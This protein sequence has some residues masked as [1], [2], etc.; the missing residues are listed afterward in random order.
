MLP[1]AASRCSP[2][3]GGPRLRGAAAL[4]GGAGRPALLLGVAEAAA[5]AR[6]DGAGWPAVWS[7]ALSLLAVVAAA[8]ARRAGAADRG[9]GPVLGA[10]ALGGGRGRPRRPWSPTPPR[11]PLVR[12]APRRLRARRRLRRGRP[13]RAHRGC[14]CRPGRPVRGVVQVVAGARRRARAGA[15]RAGRRA[16]LGRPAGRRARRRGGRHDAGPA[17][18]GWVAGVLLTASSW[19]RLALADVDAPEAYTVPAGVALLVLGALRRRRDPAYGSWQAYGSGLS[20]GAGAQ[21]AAR[22]H[23]RRRPAAAA[24][25]ARRGRCPRGRRGPPAAG[26]AAPGRGWCSPSTRWCSSR[27]T[28]SRRTTRCRAGSPSAARPR[29]AG[30]RRDVRAA[31]PGPAP[32]RAARRST[33]LTG[34]TRRADRRGASPDVPRC[35]YDARAPGRGRSGD[36]RAAGACPAP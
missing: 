27:R 26:A 10:V 32:G 11:W 13:A 28:S 6:Y 35:G 2:V 31:C 25:G 33:G 16:A 21:P 18:L 30:R 20:P 17:R 22:G 1:A 14:R 7:L 24:A 4:A 36:L 8:A 19:V 3:P 5:L 15:R 29:S 23:R 12:R 9:R 34:E